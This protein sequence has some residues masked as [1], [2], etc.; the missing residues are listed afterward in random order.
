MVIRFGVTNTSTNNVNIYYYFS[1]APTTIPNV[2]YEY[3]LAYGVLGSGETWQTDFFSGSYSGNMNIS[4]TS[5]KYYSLHKDTE[6]N[7][8]APGESAVFEM[9][10]TVINYTQN[11]ST[12]SN[13]L[14]ANLVFRVGHRQGKSL[15]V[16]RVATDE[17]G[18]SAVDVIA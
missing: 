16:K 1:S 9:R 6:Y 4:G 13:P 10:F 12:A 11:I 7:F 15:G 17:L 8:L 2:E 18:G 5:D 3:Q 14:E